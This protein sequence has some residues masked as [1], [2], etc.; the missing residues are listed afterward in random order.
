[1]RKT[2]PQALQIVDRD[3]TADERRL[4]LELRLLAPSQQEIIAMTVHGL[5]ADRRKECVARPGLRL[6]S[7]GAA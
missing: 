5:A 3:F 6:V 2:K 1:M 7:G 4:I